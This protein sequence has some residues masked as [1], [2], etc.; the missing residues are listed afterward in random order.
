MCPS[1]LS[2]LPSRF[3]MILGSGLV[4]AQHFTAITP[5]RLGGATFPIYTALAAL[6]VNLGVA[7]G[8]TPVLDALRIPRKAVPAT[9]TVLA[10]R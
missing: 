3:G 6:I 2:G 4:A 7:I 9:H 10:A 8:F 5:L 1:A